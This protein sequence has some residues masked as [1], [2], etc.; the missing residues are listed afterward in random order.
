MNNQETNCLEIK[1]INYASINKQDYFSNILIIFTNLLH[2][3]NNI[4]KIIIIVSSKKKKYLKINNFSECMKYFTFYIFRN[5][6]YLCLD[7]VNVS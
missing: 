4:K 7:I 1:I 6:L 3:L 2:N 5:S